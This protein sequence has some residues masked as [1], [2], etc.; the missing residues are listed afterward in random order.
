MVQKA[1]SESVRYASQRS[2][3]DSISSV[4]IG[5][6]AMTRRRRVFG[7]PVPVVS[8]GFIP[9]P[10]H[11]TFGYEEIGTDCAGTHLVISTEP[12]IAVYVHVCPK[13]SCD[14]AAADRLHELHGELSELCQ[15][16]SIR[17]ADKGRNYDQRG[18]VGV[19]WLLST[20]SEANLS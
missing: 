8:R 16:F 10:H 4:S 3:P 13:L 17:P 2:R 9:R 1:E 19:I 6:L 14:H 11:G 12:V 7:K 18:P 5:R 20:L 15:A